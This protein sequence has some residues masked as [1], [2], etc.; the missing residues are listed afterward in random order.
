MTAAVEVLVP[1][2]ALLTVKKALGSLPA[3]SFV[4]HPTSRVRR[5]LVVS[6]LEVL[7][8]AHGRA[9]L[10]G[11]VQAASRRDGAALVLF[12]L[13]SMAGVATGLALL[14]AVAHVARQTRE[15]PF[16][17][18][19]PDAVRRIVLARR[20]GAEKE[21][22]ASVNIEDGK[23]VAWTCE[24]KR[25]E[26]AVSD[27]P[28]LANLSP[29]A[30][31]RYELSDSGS[32]L[33]WPDSDVDLN[34]DTIREYADPDVRHEHEARARQEAARYAGA[35]RRLREERGLKQSDIEGLTDRQV[36]RL[37]QGDTVPQIDTLKKL[38][39]AHGM[40][41]DAYLGELARRSRRA[42]GRPAVRR[43]GRHANA[44]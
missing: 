2:S 27:I 41:I 29:D 13:A 39:A 20:G 40:H 43:S 22:M 9:A 23:L 15:E 4:S 26:V 42:P 31:P 10:A 44:R 21:L 7:G 36:R 30:L 5:Q 17:A 11:L 3:T 18:P 38:A 1:E 33:R 24:P 19:S 12:A 6:P 14:A 37:E 28:V 25:L 16:I 8:T 34:L 32:R 35:I